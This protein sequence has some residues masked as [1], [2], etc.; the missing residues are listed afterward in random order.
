MNVKKLIDLLK[1]FDPEAEVRLSVSMPGRVIETHEK[2]WVADYGGGPQIG[3]A[4][5][6]RGFHVYVG[7]GI[8]QF[9]REI[10]D[11]VP[12]DLGQ[13]DSPEIA[14]KV[15]DFYVFHTGLE[16]PLSDPDFDY[17]SWIPPRTT[18]GEYNEHIARL[19]REKL[20]RE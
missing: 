5:D 14:A 3:A 18:S 17:E 16:E 11:R 2:I 13:Y 9:V 20:L 15:R 4:L 12:I 1:R 8:E 19:L 6:F 7:C 10:P